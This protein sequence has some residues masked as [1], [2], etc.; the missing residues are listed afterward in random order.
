QQLSSSWGFSPINQTTEQI[1]KQFI[2]QGQSFYQASGDSGAYKGGIMSPA[3]DPNVTV[4][5]GTSLATSGADGPWQSESTWTGS[6]G[7]VST[8]YPIPSYQ[9][10]LSMAANGGSLTMRNIPDVSLPAEVQ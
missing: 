1:F 9:Q 6:G 10:G 4:V 5:G 7:G 2:A 3:D 8:S